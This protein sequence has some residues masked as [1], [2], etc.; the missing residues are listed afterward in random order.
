ML[1]L[2]PKFDHPDLLVG[3]ETS[4]DAGVFRLRED[5]A[6]VNTVD[7]FTPI[8]DDPFVFPCAPSVNLDPQFV[9]PSP[10][11]RFAI[12]GKGTFEIT[13]VRNRTRDWVQVLEAVQV[14]NPS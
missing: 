3:P 14:I 8:V 7:F 10:I 9:V 6:I 11:D 13:A 4:D 2:L 12:D 1:R 5:L